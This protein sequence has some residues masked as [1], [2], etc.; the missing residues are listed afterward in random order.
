MTHNDYDIRRM[1]GTCLRKKKMT[2]SR[3][4]QL[5]RRVYE[6]EGKVLYKYHC[7]ICGG[8]HVTKVPQP[9]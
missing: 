4:N 8:W 1:V 6:T 9:Q 2:E 7:L 5:I 3:T